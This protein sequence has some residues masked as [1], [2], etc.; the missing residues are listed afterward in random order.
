V[1]FE[2]ILVFNDKINYCDII[3]LLK[4]IFVILNIYSIKLN[5]VF[6]RNINMDVCYN[7]LFK[8][9]ID[10]GMNKTTFAKEVGIS[11]STLA[12]LSKNE[13]VNLHILVK[14]CRYFDCDINDILEI[15]K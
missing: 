4:K 8:L 13:N 12:K 9:L 2:I 11:S 3:N 5:F 7:K 10:K 1:N 6:W 15:N 14:I